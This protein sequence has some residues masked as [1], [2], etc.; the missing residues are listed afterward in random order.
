[1]AFSVSSPLPSQMGGKRV[2]RVDFISLLIQKAEFFIHLPYR[3]V[4]V[5][6]WEISFS[7]FPHCVQ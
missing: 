1:M 2:A 4:V 6:T 5:I 7:P 3:V